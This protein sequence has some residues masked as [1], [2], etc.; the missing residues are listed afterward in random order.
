MSS[1]VSSE[2]SW[3]LSTYVTV[4]I[5]NYGFCKA[6]IANDYL[7]TYVRNACASYS[8]ENIHIANNKST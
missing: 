8:L 3:V 4:S 7:H 1:Y 6:Q 2:I 5:N